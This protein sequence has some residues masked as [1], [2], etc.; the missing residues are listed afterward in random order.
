MENT[1]EKVEKAF[2]NLEKSIINPSP[3]D[4]ERDGAIQRFE[5]SVELLWKAAKRVLKQNGIEA[6]APKDV[7][8]ELAYISWIDNPEDYIFF[9]NLRNESSHAYHEEVAKKVYGEIKRFYHLGIE[10]IEMLK[11]KSK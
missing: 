11:S 3:S 7:I 5:Y 4:L 6:I 1:F 10:L 9:I 8:R 2:I